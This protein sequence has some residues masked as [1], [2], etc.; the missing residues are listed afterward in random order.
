MRLLL[1]CCGVLFV[2]SLGAGQAEA[3]WFEHGFDDEL[4]QSLPVAAAPLRLDP[5]QAP[6]PDLSRPEPSTIHDHAFVGLRHDHA[7]PTQGRI[8]ARWRPWP[9][10]G[11]H[12]PR[13]DDEP[14]NAPR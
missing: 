7:Q 13:M 2:A 6:Q 1:T 10:H 12:I 11:T 3:S 5:A 9:R 14:P 8:A 4:T